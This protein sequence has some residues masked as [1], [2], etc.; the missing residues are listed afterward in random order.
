[1]KKQ[2]NKQM[3]NAQNF[4]SLKSGTERRSSKTIGSFLDVELSHTLEYQI[5]V[6]QCHDSLLSRQH[7]TARMRRYPWSTK[8]MT[9]GDREDM[10]T[11]R[12]NT[13]S[14][15]TSSVSTVLGA[16]TETRV[17]SVVYRDN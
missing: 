3:W 5:K 11:R 16:L 9:A 7:P 6:N 4:G 10:R 2:S 1:M 17:I 12:H 8:P 14:R 13:A 15:K